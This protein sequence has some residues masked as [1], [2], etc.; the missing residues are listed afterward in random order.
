MVVYMYPCQAGHYIKQTRCDNDIITINKKGWDDVKDVLNE[1]VNV[2]DGG[3]ALFS[4]QGANSSA[5]MKRKRR[6]I[7]GLC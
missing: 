6:Q 4:S 5:E 1:D 3:G 2:R 7:A